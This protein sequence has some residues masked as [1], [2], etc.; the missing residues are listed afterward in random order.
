[1][2]SP[3]DGLTHAQREAVTHSG[4]PVLAVGGPGTGKTRVVTRRFAWL[5][6]QGT[7]AA[8]ILVLSSSPSAAAALRAEIEASI[9]PPWEELWVATVEDFSA[10]LL[11]HEP[12]EAGLDPFFCAVTRADRVAMLR[13][14]IDELALRHHEIRGNPVPLLRG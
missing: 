11:E 5:V 8:S 2:P 7:P 9:D 6:E 3:L 10:R 12:L 14:R 13:D 4:G 1:M